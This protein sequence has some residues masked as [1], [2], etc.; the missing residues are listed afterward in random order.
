MESIGIRLDGNAAQQVESR[1]KRLVVLLVRRNV[2]LR[3][4]LLRAFGGEMAAHG[5]LSLGVGAYFELVRHI[6]QHFDIRRDALRLDRPARRREI[7][8][9]GQ[10]QGA[11]TGTGT[12]RL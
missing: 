5:R 6:L 12:E 9:R 3:T 2:G 4:G 7:A 1:G 8:R 11:V 10:R